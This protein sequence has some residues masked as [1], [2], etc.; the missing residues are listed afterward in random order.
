MHAET[1]TATAEAQATELHLRQWSAAPAY[2]LRA[3]LRTVH[4]VETHGDTSDD[5]V[6]W[7]WVHVAAHADADDPIEDEDENRTAWLGLVII[8]VAFALGVATGGWL[9]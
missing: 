7:R 5:L 1:Y 3:H 9:F 2:E 4:G 8:V 6:S